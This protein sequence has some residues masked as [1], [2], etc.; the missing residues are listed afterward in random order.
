MQVGYLIQIKPV[1]R[2]LTSWINYLYFFSLEAVPIWSTKD[3]IRQ[4][5][6]DSFKNTYP[7]TRCILDCTG[8]F[9]Q[10]SSSLKLVSAIFYQIFIFSQNDSPLKTTKNVFILSKKLFSFSRY[11]NFC[12]FSPSF[13]YFPDP[14]GQVEV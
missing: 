7:N 1:S 3:Q 6:P 13:P 8:L 2:M 4:S 10:S 11:S 9:C 14:K 5:M 12:H